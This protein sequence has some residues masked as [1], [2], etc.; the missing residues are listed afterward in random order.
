MSKMIL[1]LG[2]MTAIPTMTMAQRYD[3]DRGQIL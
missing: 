2:V 3:N 1:A